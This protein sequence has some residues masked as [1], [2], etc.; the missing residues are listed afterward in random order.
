MIDVKYTREEAKD[1]VEGAVSEIDGFFSQK[2]KN[3]A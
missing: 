3:P 2:T 1:I